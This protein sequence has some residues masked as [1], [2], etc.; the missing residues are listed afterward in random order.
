MWVVIQPGRV[1]VR[2]AVSAK[3]LAAVHRATLSLGGVI[4]Y[5]V[6]D[7]CIAKTEDQYV[8]LA[9]RLAA[10]ATGRAALRR[11]LRTRIAGSVICDEQAYA[12]RL[13]TAL[14]AMWR[15]RCA[16]GPNR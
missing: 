15:E 3:E 16:A 12:R 7:E 4:D 8:K 13:A 11:D 5:A 2:V 10:D 9:A 6:L 14:R 1:K